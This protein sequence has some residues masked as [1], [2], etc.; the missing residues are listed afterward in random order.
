[1]L[2][3]LLTKNGEWHGFV[4]L[5]VHQMF[6]TIRRFSAVFFRR[7]NDITPASESVNFGSQNATNGLLVWFATISKC[8]FPSSPS[9]IPNR[10][11]VD[12]T[13]V[14]TVRRAFSFNAAALALTINSFLSSQQKPFQ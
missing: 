1:M 3:S 7:W 8:L 13:A 12:G 14:C 5:L 4:R 6:K 9:Q 2:A 11:I 10:L